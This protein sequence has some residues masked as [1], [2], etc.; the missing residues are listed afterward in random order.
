MPGIILNLKSCNL[1][2]QNRFGP[3]PIQLKNTELY[4][5]LL[6]TATYSCKIKNVFTNVELNILK[7]DVN[8]FLSMHINYLQETAIKISLRFSVKTYF[9]SDWH[10][11]V[12]NMW[13]AIKSAN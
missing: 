11:G 2:G 9:K 10:D 5:I 12:Y 4:N 3:I 7:P 1:L 8:W 6:L 13:I